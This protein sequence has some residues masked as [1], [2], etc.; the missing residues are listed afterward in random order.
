MLHRIG[1]P[2]VLLGHSMGTII[3]LAP[4]R[5]G[6][7]RSAG[8]IFVGGL[9][10]ARPEIKERLDAARCERS[11]GR[12]WH[13]TGAAV[14]AANF[15]RATIGAP[16]G[17][18]RR[19]SSACS[20]RRIPTSTCAAA[21]SSSHA[22]AAGFPAACACPACQSAARRTSTR[23]PSSCQ[24]RARDPRLQ[25]RQ[26]LTECGSFPVPRTARRVRRRGAV[27]RPIVCV[28]V[29]PHDQPALILPTAAC[30][31]P[32]GEARRSSRASHSL[33]N[34]KDFTGWKV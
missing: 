9:P 14:G 23:R 21:G 34:G 33:F 6:P 27:L 12:A 19:C 10:E 32:A 15:S 24:L 4:R 5:P 25:R 22:S 13:G 30:V 16:A 7:A 8:C 18:G 29:C 2:V 11:S 3:A 17:A 31:H 1:E 20:T 26:M 28:R